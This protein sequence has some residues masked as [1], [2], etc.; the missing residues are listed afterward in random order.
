MMRRN[1]WIWLIVFVGWL[2]AGI[3][4]GTFL[5]LRG[6]GDA[7]A[8]VQA[9]GVLAAAAWGLRGLYVWRD[10][11]W[12]GRLTTVLIG[13]GV[14]AV[15]AGLA[16]IMDWYGLARAI[17]S[18]YLMAVA[19]YLGLMLARAAL[20]PGHPIF[21][22]ARTL[23]DEAIRMKAPLV[24]IV[25]LLLVLPILPFVSGNETRLE[26]RVQ[27]F[28]T[29]SMMAVGAL[30]SLMTIF[31]A[32]GTISGEL[33]QRQV[34]LSL[35]K[36][37][38]RGQYLAGKALGIM[39]LNLL[40]VAVAGGGIYAFTMLLADQPAQ[41]AFDANAVRD[42][43][44]VARQVVRPEPTGDVDI[45]ELYAQRLAQ[46]RQ[47]DPQ[48]FGD[49]D[50]PNAP[51]APELRE[52]ILG[53]IIGQWYSIGPRDTRSFL[54]RG[55]KGAAEHSDTVQLRLQPKMSGADF[56]VPML[57]RV[58]GRPYTNRPGS[59]FVRLSEGQYH[60][61]PIPVQALD[62][63]GDVL[64]EVTNVPLEGREPKTLSFNP[65]DGIEMLYRVGGFEPNLV[66][67]LGLMWVK[68]VF[69]G[70]LGLAAGT[71]LSFPIACLL[72]LTVYFAAA[73]SEYL[74]ESL[75]YY[76][77]EP[78]AL[79]GLL[80]EG[81]LYEAF[82]VVVRLVGSGFMMLVPKFGEYDG[83]AL[84]SDGR[85]LSLEMLGRA[86]LWIGV[87]STGVAAV[88]G[89]LVFRNRELAQVTV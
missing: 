55:M 70:M 78:G 14:A 40:L 60:V 76:G 5:R 25:A 13:T 29:W 69:L 16:A 46:L 48:T 79:L 83:T 9:I 86:V 44:L 26:Y 31:L 7:G 58:N 6:M 28:L 72:C 68:L 49:P 24:F 88:L 47:Q 73:G 63:N 3:G 27:S 41:D 80:S 23:L 85:L 53:Q 89:W 37:V 11:T 18:M 17:G 34:F 1:A 84:V 42:R 19:F 87:V 59:P 38:S 75:E 8:W 51:I 81:E 65:A 54:F 22:V 52:Q 35:T 62:E 64:L 2:A 4:L 39:V 61:L 67:A 43:V 33:R 57:I 50:R 66:R 20:S 71:Y 82:K 74:F 30:L 77:S 45:E 12:V 15:L 10:L 36:P 56:E 21:G 32:V